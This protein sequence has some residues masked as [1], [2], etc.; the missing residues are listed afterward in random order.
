MGRISLAQ[1]QL[2][3][4]RPTEAVG[5]VIDS[6][7]N[8]NKKVQAGSHWSRSPIFQRAHSEV[9]NGSRRRS[10][11]DGGSGHRAINTSW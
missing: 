11:E 5:R 2:P 8:N 7:N 6:N 1:F 10:T 9:D 4:H 3:G